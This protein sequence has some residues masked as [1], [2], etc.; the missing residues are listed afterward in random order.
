MSNYDEYIGYSLLHWYLNCEED[1][2]NGVIIKTQIRGQNEILATFNDISE[3]FLLFGLS[4][5]NSAIVE[6]FVWVDYN[7]TITIDLDKEGKFK[8]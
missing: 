5:L 2:V 7:W 6:C 1:E 3:I 4:I 8:E